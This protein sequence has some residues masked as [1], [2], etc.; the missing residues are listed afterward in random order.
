MNEHTTFLRLAATAVDFPLEPAEGRALAQHLDG[1]DTCRSTAE[2]LRADAT[3]LR[4][5]PRRSPSP[6]VAAAIARAARGET[7]TGRPPL[8]LLGLGFLLVLGVAGAIVGGGALRQLLLDRQ[9]R[10][11]VVPSAPPSAGIV[12]PLPSAEPSIDPRLGV[13]WQMVKSASAGGS[14]ST[15]AWAVTAGGPG[16]VAVGRTCLPETS[17]HN[18]ECWGAP[19]VSSD[20]LTWRTVPRQAALEIGAYYPTSGPGADMI[21]VAARPDAIVAIGYAVDG[22]RTID[23]GGIFRAAVW[24]SRDGRAWERVPYSPIFDGARFNDVAATEQGFVIVGADYR[25]P[26]LQGKPRGAIWTSQDGRAWQRV[27]DGPIFDIGGYLDTG[28]EPGSGG[29]RRVISSGAAILA[30]GAVCNDNG[31]GCRPAF[32]SSPDG[33][34]WD[35]VVLEEPNTT[36]SEVVTTPRG[37]VAVGSASNTDGCGVGLPPCKALVFTSTDGRSWQRHEVKVPDRSNAPDAFTDALAIGDR[38]LAIS[39]ELDGQKQVPSTEPIID[40][41]GAGFWSSGDGVNWTP[42]DGIPHDF[43]PSSY[44][45]IAAGPDRVVI[46]GDLN[47]RIAVSPKG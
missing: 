32:W 15:A 44:Q 25:A 24:L 3:A 8:L 42:M 47:G 9:A 27:P 36:A 21:G 5:L 18:L 46:V 33:S 29:P 40:A 19:Q 16:F 11:A 20:G 28:E 12:L 22:A 23:Q 30:V 10:P 39:I 4:S 17:Q 45:P 38:I 7:R 26:A 34:T 37:F 13:E 43:G 41:T 31:L 1:C 14:S 2:A 6:H 35:R